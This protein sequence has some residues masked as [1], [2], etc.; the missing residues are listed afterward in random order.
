MS[1][2][3]PV[4]LTV[5]GTFLAATLESCRTLHNDTAGSQA[6]IKAARAL[7]DLSHQ[8]YAPLPGGKAG[9]V[10]FVDWWQDAQGLMDFFQNETVQMQ[11]QKLFSS[12]DASVW[13][14]ARGAFTYSLPAAAGR[15][16]RYLGMIR[17]PIASPDR[18]LAVFRAADE[19]AQRT[20]RARGI[21]SHE[22]FIRLNAPGDTTPPQLLGVDV[23]CDLAGMQA[24]YGDPKEMAA[25]EGAFA[26]APDPSTWQQAPGHWSEW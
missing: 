20:A 4:F 15:N 22:L 11:G 17:G 3:T 13:M 1:S 8:V 21:L 23:W 10:L 7:G 18:A 6:G 16:E 9:E 12:R 19:K 5:R 2:V 14:P 25:L 24:H 26:G